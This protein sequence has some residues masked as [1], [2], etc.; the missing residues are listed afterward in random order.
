MA[1]GKRII[2]GLNGFCLTRH[3]Y[4][5]GM[6]VL[7]FSRHRQVE[8]AVEKVIQTAVTVIVNRVV[9]TPTTILETRTALL[10]TALYLLQRYFHLSV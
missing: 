10:Q 6:V 3:H 1:G 8:A 5:I 9:R 7:A 2:P 4:Y